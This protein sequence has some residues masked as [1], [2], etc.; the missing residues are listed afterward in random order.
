MFVGV[1]TGR[2]EHFPYT[3]RYADPIFG[4]ATGAFAYI[5]WERD[6]KNE[7][8]RPPGKT[9][10]ELVSRRVNGQE[11]SRPIKASFSKPSDLL[12]KQ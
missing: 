2:A 3:L 12:S 9:L 4:I 6:P 1:P 10:Q 5:L 7:Q 11:P 8:E